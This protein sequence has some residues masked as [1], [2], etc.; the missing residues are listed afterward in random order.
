MSVELNTL[1]SDFRKKIANSIDVVGA[2]ISRFQI[3]HPFTFDDGDHFVILL[4]KTGGKFVLT[5]EG[6]TLMHLSYSDLDLGKGGYKE[7]IDTTVTAFNLN[8]EHGE[9]SL[10]IPED[11]Y[12]DAL[13]SYLQA[14]TKIADIKYLVRE[15]IKSLFFQE[16]KAY[17]SD[18]IPESK[19]TFDY[20]N[21]KLDT[22]KI[23]PVD[24]RLE[25]S[26]KPIFIFGIENDNKCQTATNI[27]Y[28]WEKQQEPFEVMA[29]HEN[30]EDLNRRVLARFSD[31][32]GRQFSSLPSNRERIKD[33]IVEKLNGNKIPR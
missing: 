23:Y 2:G 29:I 14:L 26:S 31:V 25:T 11:R 13:F 16:L 15:R 1:K 12:G 10:D 4:K 18:T 8:N 22:Q 19:R 33:F 5:D 6:H 7:I 21:A 32:C 17:L 30:Q 3:L 28:W 9:L 24:C 20:C 27:I